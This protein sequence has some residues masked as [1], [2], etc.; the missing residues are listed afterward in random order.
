MGLFIQ[1][2][3]ACGPAGCSEINRWSVCW[4]RDVGMLV[5]PVCGG[6][7]YKKV[8]VRDGKTTCTSV[9]CSQNA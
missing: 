4:S 9:L 1:P 3:C 2:N 5:C 7:V 8:C 6:G